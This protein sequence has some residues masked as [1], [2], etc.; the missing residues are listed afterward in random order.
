M[1]NFHHQIKDNITRSSKTIFDKLEFSDPLY[2]SDETLNFLLSEELV[3]CSLEG[4][5]LRTRS[6]RVKSPVVLG[7]SN[8]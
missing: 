2:L 5:P 3:G 1:T 8:S 6:K 4:L 7:L